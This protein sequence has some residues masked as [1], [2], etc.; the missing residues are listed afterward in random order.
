MNKNLSNKTRLERGVIAGALA[1]LF[2]GSA[3]AVAASALGVAVPVAS[4]YAAAFA[5]AALCVAGTLTGGAIIASLGFVVVAGLYLATHGAGLAGL[6]ALFATWSGQ[7]ADSAGAAAGGRLLLTCAGFTLGA[8]FFALLNHDEFVSVAIVALLAVFVACHATSE[9][10]SL[11][12]AVPGLVAAASAFALT[13]GVQRDIR[14]LRVLL[15]AALA[16]AVAVALVPGGRVTWTPPSGSGACSS[17]TSASPTSA[18]PSP[19][20]RRA[21]ITPAKWG[22]RWCRCWAARRSPTPTRSCG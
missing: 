2:A 1:L 18:S 15:P 16:L 7:A 17:S 19:S 8:L 12:A 9:S 6:R 3:A 22:I 4:L 11:G 14:A 21:T 20:T 10:A 13:G 5:A